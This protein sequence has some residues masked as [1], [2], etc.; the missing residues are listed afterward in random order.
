MLHGTGAATVPARAPIAPATWWTLAALTVLGA[1]LRLIGLGRESPWN[2][3]LSSLMQYTRP[4]LWLAAVSTSAE[5]VP[6][7]WI[8]M[9]VWTRIAGDS[10][11]MLRLPSALF[12]IATIPAMFLLGRRWYGDG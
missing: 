9:H 2:D 1:G 7:Y 4:T 11:A 8:L 5:H 12:G 6:G 10:D 3:E